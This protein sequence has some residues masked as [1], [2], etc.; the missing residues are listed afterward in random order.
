M[1]SSKT[2]WLWSV[3][4]ATLLAFLVYW[5][6]HSFAS[7]DYEWEAKYLIP[8]LWTDEGPGLILKGLW[9]TLYY[10][11]ISIVIGTLIGAIVGLLLVGQE[12][13]LKGSA[14]VY[15]EVFRNTPLLVQLYVIYFVVGTA[16]GFN[17]ETSGILSLSLFCGAYVAEIVRGGISQ[18]DRGQWDAARALGL[19]EVR[20]IQKILFPQTLRRIIPALAGQFVSLVKDSSLI[21]VI[22]IVELTKSASNVVAITF[23]SFETWFLIAA[24]YLVLNGIFATLARKLEFHLQKST[25]S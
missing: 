6:G 15:V 13:V 23:K 7:L 10:S 19:S 11:S 20:V 16:A 17:E 14:K 4:W 3:W 21:S 18:L 1:Y 12:P 2:H 25:R 5:V 22:S 8:Y 24:L 9:G